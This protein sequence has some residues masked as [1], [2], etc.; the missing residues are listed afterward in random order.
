[1]GDNGL[2][3]AF[4]FLMLDSQGNNLSDGKAGASGIPRRHAFT[5]GARCFQFTQ[6]NVQYD[7]DTKRWGY[8]INWGFF[9][10]LHCS[11][12]GPLFWSH[13]ASLLEYQCLKYCS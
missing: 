2:H 1:M 11:V 4:R 8:G 9:L 5:L 12:F 13:R 6:I 7:E 3:R 10:S